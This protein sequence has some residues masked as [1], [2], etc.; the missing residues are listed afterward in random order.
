VIEITSLTKC[1]FDELLLVWN[2]GFSGYPMNMTTSIDTLAARFGRDGLSPEL[3]LV[4]WEGGRPVGFILNG[5]R[6]V[7]GKN[8]AWNGGTG[9]IPEYR[10]SG[11]GHRLLEACI[12]AYR[13]AGIETAYLEALAQN[14][15]AISLYERH[16]YR[17]I[18]EVTV[19]S[20]D[21]VL[22][23]DSFVAGNDEV[24]AY[25]LRRGPAVSAARLPFYR[26]FGP[27][28]TQWMNIHQGQSIILENGE[29]SPVA[30]ALFHEQNTDAG[31]IT[32]IRLFQ[33][34][35]APGVP[36]PEVAISVL[37]RE[38]YAPL[39]EAC[40]RTTSNISCKN[41][42]VISVLASAGFAVLAKQV[43]MMREL[44]G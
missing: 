11:V 8:I 43:V 23:S 17:T 4:A 29:G 34:E 25:F 9:V 12:D 31:D 1:T 15:A 2:Q 39:D 28:Q 24:T 16:G 19:L 26:A 7:Q 5:Y 3:S 14:T 13:Q 32:G 21:G 27:W 37:L 41:G 33:C 44:G 30:Y 22:S 40:R 18:D 35:I 20:R 36:L 10:R 6:L 42:A 38:V